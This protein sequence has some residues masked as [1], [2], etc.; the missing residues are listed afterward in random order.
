MQD[1]TSTIGGR[2][3]FSVG[4]EEERD[5][6]EEVG[7]VT[8]AKLG[9]FR[10]SIDGRGSGAANGHAKNGATKG[11]VGSDE[12]GFELEWEDD[13]RESTD[14]ERAWGVGG[15]GLRR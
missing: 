11:N 2:T 5:G 1:D 13:G 9:G 14:T 4:D 8:A 10:E 15:D 6:P 3:L 7:S 12:E